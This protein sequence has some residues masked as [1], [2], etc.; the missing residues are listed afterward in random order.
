MI[1]LFSV[2]PTDYYNTLIVESFPPL[3]MFR[4]TNVQHSAFSNPQK[5]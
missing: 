5:L 3:K 1:Y 4:H 2:C